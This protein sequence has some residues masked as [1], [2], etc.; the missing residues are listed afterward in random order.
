MA[1]QRFAAATSR[2][3]AAE[4]R[5]RARGGGT[6]SAH[7]LL[8]PIFGVMR[9]S[10][11]G[12]RIGPGRGVPRRRRP[13]PPARR[14]VMRKPRARR[15]ARR[16]TDAAGRVRGASRS[17]RRPVSSHPA[18]GD[19]PGACS[20]RGASALASSSAARGVEREL[21]RRARGPGLWSIAT[22]ARRESRRVSRAPPRVATH[23]GADPAAGGDR[24]AR[25]RRAES[26]KRVIAPAASRARRTS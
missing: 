13:A 12:P 19:R 18:A 17:T 14:T 16:L 21:R 11:I 6:V 22:A 8:R 26:G 5:G 2:A 24:R 15:R 7:A 3:Y 25:R 4:E 9:S 20:A 1:A 23:V 10:T